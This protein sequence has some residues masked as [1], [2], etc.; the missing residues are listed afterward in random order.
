VGTLEVRIATLLEL[1]ASS[2]T[3]VMRLCVASPDYLNLG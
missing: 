2:I 1:P 3:Y